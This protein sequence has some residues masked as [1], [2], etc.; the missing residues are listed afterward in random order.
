MLSGL[1]FFF[2]YTHMGIFNRIIVSL[3]KYLKPKTTETYYD[4]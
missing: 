3:G 2:K 4:N 1:L